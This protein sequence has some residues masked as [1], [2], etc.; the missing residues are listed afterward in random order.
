MQTPPDW[1]DLPADL[2][3]W[4][5][6]QDVERQLMWVP[7]IRGVARN[8]GEVVTMLQIRRDNDAIC[9]AIAGTGTLTA[10]EQAMDDLA[11]ADLCVQRSRD[12]H[13]AQRAGVSVAV[14]RV[15]SGR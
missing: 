11:F 6:S 5:E 1:S 15:I 12:R 13:R 10:E 14:L 8:L 4:V 9:A 2:R 7:A 3:A